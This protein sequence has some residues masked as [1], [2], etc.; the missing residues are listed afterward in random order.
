MLSPETDLIPR[1]GTRVCVQSATDAGRRLRNPFLFVVGCQRS[2]TTMLQRMFDAHPRLAVAYD[3]LFIP[4][5]LSDTPLGVDP[6]VDDAIV[7]RVRRHPR[8]GRLELDEGV[9]DEARAGNPRYSEFVSRIYDAYARMKGKELAGEKSPGYCRH[10]PRLCSVFPWVKVIH[11]IRDG[12]EVALSI[13]D[14]GKGAAK[15]DL[16]KDEPI[17]VGALWWR[18]DIILG[19]D[20][21][22]VLGEDRYIET[23]YE[24]LVAEPESESRRLCAFLGI[25]YDDQMTQYHR[26]RVR[27]GENLSAKAAW[28]PPTRG[29]RDWRRDLPDRDVE[30]FEAIAGDQISMLGYERAFPTISPGIRKV[31]QRCERWW[32]Q[33][34]T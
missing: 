5:A 26:G 20:S 3:S 29:L 28:L 17:A 27:Q 12:R 13:R 25:P 31:A 15:L 9:L 32:L 14:W 22:R 16:W 19:C 1:A 4:R 11:L 34:M 10:L 2:G 21:G 33:H 6:I 30:L 8:F 23:R 24:R 18:R 7:E